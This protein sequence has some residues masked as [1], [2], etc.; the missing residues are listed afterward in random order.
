MT[1][2]PMNA[3]SPGMLCSVKRIVR[4]LNQPFRDLWA[5]HLRHSQ[6]DRDLYLGLF[7][8]HR[9]FRNRLSNTFRSDRGL[10]QF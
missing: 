9:V 1:V 5:H 7:Q 6:A 4:T 10:V 8:G 2:V 3:I